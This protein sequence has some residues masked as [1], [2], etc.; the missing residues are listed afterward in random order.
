MNLHPILAM[1]NVR[2][3]KVEYIWLKGHNWLRESEC[4]G[5][6]WG[7]FKC[8]MRGAWRA[9]FRRI[10]KGMFLFWV[11][12]LLGRRRGTLLADTIILSAR[13]RRDEN[14]LLSY[15]PS[16]VVIFI[17][18]LKYLLRSIK[19]HVK[20]LEHRLLTNANKKQPIHAP[21]PERRAHLSLQPHWYKLFLQF[22]FFLFRSIWRVQIASW[23]VNPKFHVEVTVF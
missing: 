7:V 18:T 10:H 13:R 3:L 2:N 19:H 11:S 6:Y 8:I 16:R 23:N 5:L 20:T 15:I 22:F 17:E 9:R 4:Q 12:V 21:G 14:V 1:T